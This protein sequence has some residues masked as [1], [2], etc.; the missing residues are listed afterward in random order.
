MGNNKRNS[1]K[2]N[3]SSIKKVFFILLLLLLF[4]FFLTYKFFKINIIKCEQNSQPCNSETLDKLQHL[5]HSSLFF[6]DFDK[7]F[8]QFEDYQINKKLPNTLI[9]KLSKTSSHYYQLDENSFISTTK[10]ETLDKKLNEKINNLFNQLDK[11][12]ISYEKIS[13]KKNIFIIF[14]T[15]DVR[16]L[17]DLN[18]I[19]NGTYKLSQILKNIELKEI[20]TAIKEI[21]TRFKM[22]VLKTK[23]TII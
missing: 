19:K 20:D 14:L 16:S 17:I 5:Y 6:T 9:I 23:H 1:I 3:P 22:P 21:D 15:N 11:Y 7:T 12:E 18:D 10:Q 8:S 4:F 13:L 2:K